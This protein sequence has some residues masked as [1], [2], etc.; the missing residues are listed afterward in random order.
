M[1]ERSRQMLDELRTWMAHNNAAIIAVIC[2]AIAAK[3]IGDGISGL[4]A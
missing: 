4:S 2:L 1:G 3:L